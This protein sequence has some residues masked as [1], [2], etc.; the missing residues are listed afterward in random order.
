MRIAKIKIGIGGNRTVL[1]KRTSTEGALVYSNRAGKPDGADKT[2]DILPDQKRDNFMMSIRNQTVLKKKVIRDYLKNDFDEKFHEILMDILSNVLTG[3]DM[4]IHKVF[5]EVSEVKIN[6]YLNHRFRNKIFKYVCGN[7]EISFSLSKLIAE[8]MC[9]GNIS[10]MKP[11][12]DWVEWYIFTKSE[13]LKKSIKNNRIVIDKTGDAGTMNVSPHKRALLEWERE[14]LQNNGT[15]N[16]DEMH[17]LYGTDRL[18]EAL[19]NVAYTLA[20]KGGIHNTNEYHRN[21]K[22]ALQK[23]QREIFGSS[24]NKLNRDHVQLYAY[25]LEIVKYLAH[26]FPLKK[27]KRNTAQD[28]VKYYLDAGKIK[29]I[30]SKQLENAICANLLR[31]GKFE[32][33]SSQDGCLKNGIDSNSLS[34]QKADEAFI[35]TLI[36]HCAF[37]ASNIR[38]MVDPAQTV[39]I[40]TKK[41]LKLSLYQNQVNKELF[42]C[43]YGF[44]IQDKA[45]TKDVFEAMREIV[46]D[47]RN[48]AVHYKAVTLDKIFGDGKNIPEVFKIQFKKELENAPAAFAAQLKARGALAFFP[49]DELNGFLKN[50][51][52][53]LYHSAVPYAPGFKKV[54]KG[55]INYQNAD[56]NSMFYDLELSFY[57]NK[58]NRREPWEARYFLLKT[59]YN[60][61]FLTQFTNNRSLFKEAVNNVLKINREQ[62][63]KSKNKYAFAFN[64]IKRMAKDESIASYMTYIQS[65]LMLEK[66]RKEHTDKEKNI[67]FEKFILQIFIKGFDSFMTNNPSLEFIRSETLEEQLKGY[68]KQEIADMLDDREELIAENISLKATVIQPDNTAHIA[69]YIFCKLL[70]TPH[71]STLRNEITKYRNAA[72]SANHKHLPAIIELCLLSADMNSNS[73]ASWHK[74]QEDG[75]AG[76]MPYI[77]PGGNPASWDTLYMQT[78]KQTPVIHTP[79]ELALKYG[80]AE[81]LKSVISRNEKY[82]L[83]KDDFD[84]WKEMQPQAEED[85]QARK[86][87]H[88]QWKEL[89]GK[90]MQDFIEKNGEDYINLCKTV[91]NYNWLDNKVHFLHLKNLHN[92]TIDILGRLAGFIALFERDFQYICR[93][94]KM[95]EQSDGL[96]ELDFSTGLPLFSKTKED[97]LKAIFLSNNYR[98]LRNSIVH[99]NFLTTVHKTE[100]EVRKKNPEYQKYSIMDMINELRILFRYDRKLKNAVS[101]S[102]I[103][104]FSKHGMILKMKFDVQHNLIVEDIAPKELIHF[105]GQKFE[106]K[107]ITTNQVRPVYCDMC[108]TLLELKKTE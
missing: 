88:D 78:G 62:A 97:Y 27:S 26:Y 87:L 7:R 86:S 39:D 47:I 68:T 103:D 73:Y 12:R 85:I 22:K 64:G 14:F 50:N 5:A 58:D 93:N 6:S 60:N 10:P 1:I 55:G 91:D 80:T 40:L 41:R 18:A 45:I 51:E 108:K 21:L 106:G 79:A 71:L 107:A 8:S 3:T 98:P 49:M 92:L 54:M 82:L 33:H 100:A 20:S 74:P 35:L 28:T 66:D 72:N 44:D 83:R 31:Q 42:R 4:K 84:K 15:I 52:F 67:N 23:H 17:S 94:R 2:D 90:E 76:I 9:K 25:N 43:F 29:N 38:N 57:L 105:R 101:K 65:Y 75:L 53:E 96:D 69:F 13:K 95:N 61:L 16:L 46:A 34:E 63:V 59:I 89:K 24:E 37:A 30:I 77:E 48:K 32:L 99:F 104:L 11:Y 70:N 81:V 102:M 19:K 36:G 56:K